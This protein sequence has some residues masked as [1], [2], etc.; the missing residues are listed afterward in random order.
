MGIMDIVLRS[1]KSILE[2]EYP[3]YEVIVVDNASDDGSF[4]RIRDFVK[5]RA[6]DRR[7]VIKLL[8]LP[9]NKSYDGG[10]NEGFK[11]RDRSSKYVI[12]MNNDIIV[13]PETLKV[14]VETA[15]RSGKIG[16]I[17]GILLSYWKPTVI[18]SAGGVINELLIPGILF[19]GQ[20]INR[21][22]ARRLYSVTY[23]EASLA[24]YNIKAVLEVN[25]GLE[26]LYEPWTIAYYD[27]VVISLKLWGKGYMSLVCSK[28]IGLH[29]R[30]QT[31]KALGLG[32]TLLYIATRNRIA[33]NEITNS[34]F[35]SIIRTLII[36]RVLRYPKARLVKALRRGLEL[37]RL[38]KAIGLQL[39]LYKAPIAYVTRREAI[40]ALSGSLSKVGMRA[41]NR[42]EEKVLRILS[43]DQMRC[44]L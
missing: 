43:G 29:G 9:M 41:H 15:E 8:R 42:F 14:L 7:P 11:A 10:V 1:L 39:D 22:T 20:S 40:E 33:L 34:R 13:F 16:A 12:A 19:S 30:S 31:F 23:A 27:D 21:V 35:K 18:D 32:P 36:K 25:E 4:E 38:L 6:R 2:L 28:A 44:D 37:G 17:N 24:L 5:E 3:D 26:I